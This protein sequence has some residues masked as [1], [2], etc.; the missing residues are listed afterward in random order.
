M[1][2][3]LLTLICDFTRRI[4]LDTFVVLLLLTICELA[5]ELS[6]TLRLFRAIL[7]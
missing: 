6:L 5:V 1:I 3:G 2:F 4:D 7:E